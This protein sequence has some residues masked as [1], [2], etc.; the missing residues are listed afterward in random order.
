MAKPVQRVDFYLEFHS[1]ARS[2]LTGS[3]SASCVGIDCLGRAFFSPHAADPVE[4]TVKLA[5]KVSIE[6][7]HI[8]IHNVAECQ[9]NRY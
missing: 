1:T 8:E 2:A 5:Q 6:D 4:A 7:A 9:R 3:P